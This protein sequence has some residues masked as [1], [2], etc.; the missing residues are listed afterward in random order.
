MAA[1]RDRLL[2]R[3]T[4]FYHHMYKLQRNVNFLLSPTV[5]HVTKYY[6]VPILS[7]SHVIYMYT[8]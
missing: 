8:V 3:N 5:G 7:K 1:L 6:T 4:S 2:Q